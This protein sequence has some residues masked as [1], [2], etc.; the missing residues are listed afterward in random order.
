MLTVMTH[1]KINRYLS[2]EIITPTVMGVCLFTVIVL[3]GRILRLAEMVLNKGVPLTDIIL[4]F[5]YTMASFLV[6]TLP[7]SFLMGIL[8]AFGRLSSDSEIVALKASGVGLQ[9]MMR[10]TMILALVI[11][12]ITGALSLSLAPASNNAFRSKLFEIASSRA[13]IGIQ[14]QVFN[15]EFDDIV[16]YTSAIDDKTGSMSGVFISDER[17]NTVPATISAS[18]GQIV[19]DQETQTLTLHLEEGSVHRQSDLDGEQAYQVIAFQTYDINLDLGGGLTQTG[20]RKKKM[21]QLSGTDLLD[22]ADSAETEAE[23]MTFAVEFLDRLLMPLTPILFALI[24]LPL[25]IQ[26]TRSGRGGGFAIGLAIF[27]TYYIVYSLN[28]TLTLDLAITEYTMFIPPLLFLFGGAYIYSL[29]T[30]EKRFVLLDR[31]NDFFRKKRK[32]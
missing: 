22:A 28:K 13:S 2:R 11:S 30:Q 19:S 9:Q 10:P 3:I 5:I 24:G 15:S 31:I 17:M 23:R 18:S 4:L 20:K 25:G 14:P 7:F 21:N 1:Q 26:S 16:L 27:L 29:A 8:I 12:L 32:G 6:L